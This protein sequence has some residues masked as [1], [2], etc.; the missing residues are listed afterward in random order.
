MPEEKI[1]LDE[2][3]IKVTNARFIVPAQTYAL[4]GVTSVKSLREDPSKKWPIILLVIGAIIMLAGFENKDGMGGIFVG[5]LI[6]AGGAF[7]LYSIKPNFF[8][9]LNSSSGEARSLE[10]KD[11]GFISRVIS[12]LNDAIIHRG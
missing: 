6:I 1:F 7:W 10:S 9:V 8:V 11:S 2:G 5:I 4:S 12:A 3:G